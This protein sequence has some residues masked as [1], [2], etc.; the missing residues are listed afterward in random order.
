MK[1]V[2]V[3]AGIYTACVSESYHDVRIPKF[4]MPKDDVV[5]SGDDWRAYF[6]TVDETGTVCQLVNQ[7]TT[8]ID[9]TEANYEEYDW[10][11]VPENKS[12]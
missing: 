3:N 11:Q 7:P 12:K 1:K 5:V 2:K 10:T 8:W 4:R 9:V 6:G